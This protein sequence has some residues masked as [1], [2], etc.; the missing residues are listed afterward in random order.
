MKKLLLFSGVLVFCSGV[1]AQQTARMKSNSTATYT[2]HRVVKKTAGGPH[3][4]ATDQSRL[5]AHP[6]A[7]PAHRNGNTNSASVVPETVIG[8]TVYDLQTNG[9]LS[10][11][12]INENGKIS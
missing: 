6:K 5:V 9:T 1:F 3:E 10:N 8:S 12:V 7:H 11:R 4:A 2:P